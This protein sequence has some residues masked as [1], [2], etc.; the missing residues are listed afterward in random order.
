[1]KQFLRR[2]SK[3]EWNPTTGEPSGETARA[4]ALQNMAREEQR[5][6]PAHKY[7][8]FKN[9]FAKGYLLTEQLIAY[10]PRDNWQRLSWCGR[11]LQYDPE[12]PVQYRELAPDLGVLLLGQAFLPQQVE[13]EYAA[14]ADALK[15]A[16]RKDARGGGRD[17]VDEMVRSLAGRF[18]VIVCRDGGLDLYADPMATRTCYY[19]RMAV[20]GA[21]EGWLLASHSGLIAEAVGGL[22]SKESRQ[23]LHH[24]DY[25][26][27]YGKWIPGLATP[28]DGVGQVYANGRIR[29]AGDTASNT[30]FFPVAP[31]PAMSAAEAAE[32]FRSEL[33][34][35]IDRWLRVSPVSVLALTS[36]RDST[37]ILHAG[38]DR[39]QNGETLAM[40]YHP[41][42]VVTKSTRNDVAT[43]NKVAAAAG[44][45][46]LVVD[47]RELPKQHPM[48]SLY[49][50]TFS[51]WSRY[52]NLAWAMYINVPAKASLLLGVGGGI[53]TGMYKDKTAPKPTPNVLAAKFTSSPFAES[54]ELRNAIASW[55]EF[56][57]FTPN[58]LQSYPFLDLW[59]WEHRMSKWA[60]E[61][62]SEFDLAVT[63]APILNSRR[64]LTAALS[65]PE[66]MRENA[67]LYSYLGDPDEAL[68]QL[69]KQ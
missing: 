39:F 25:Q 31:I 40:T 52:P 2:F 54:S 14:V 22:S 68:A 16:L 28:H 33:Q 58:A 57:D 21:E 65:L 41:F 24:R 51:G 59:H 18:V 67:W 20:G 27:S 63:P 56:V 36:G 48:R 12:L 60:G 38:L 66:P 69:S 47:V 10:S 45:R 6:R 19:A 34:L 32:Q 55:C 23:L 29:L 5:L 46:H 64:L 7:W 3:F 15:R 61:W 50:R 13:P 9:V 30:R 4:A 8:G 26:D 49:S 35:Q 53:V 42:R 1:M 17:H 62:Y 44:L 43:A 37:A 11:W